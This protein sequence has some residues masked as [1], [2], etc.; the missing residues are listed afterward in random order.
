MDKKICNRCHIE[1]NLNDFN[2]AKGYKD[3][4]R[5]ICKKCKYEYDR[6]WLKSNPEN[7]KKANESNRNWYKKTEG[8]Y[9]KKW[10]N[11][12]REHINKLNSELRNGERKSFKNSY[13]KGK[14][15]PDVS[16]ENNPNWKGGISSEREK[17]MKSPEYRE[18]RFGVLKRDNYTC[19]LCI[20]KAK[21]RHVHHIVPWSKDETL[22]YQQ[23][24]GVTLCIP[25]HNLVFNNEDKFEERFKDYVSGKPIVVLSKGEK[26]GLAAFDANCEYCKKDIIVPNWKKRNKIHFCNIE[27]KKFFEKKIKFNWKHYN[28]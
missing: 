8:E 1:K 12:N 14:K 6:Q 22:R 18:W 13:W 7:Q 19:V 25:C 5:S 2:K 3:G 16:G 26:Q 28:K 21:K 4:Y 9:H 11:E 17:A 10:R 24:N 27:C 23:S 20:L 15:R